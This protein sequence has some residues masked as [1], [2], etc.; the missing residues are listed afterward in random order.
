[1]RDAY[2]KEILDLAEM[3]N[4]DNPRL[5]STYLIG[6]AVTTM[7]ALAIVRAMDERGGP[8]S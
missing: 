1:M 7:Q 5:A 3:V 6:L 8:Q 4:P 2:V